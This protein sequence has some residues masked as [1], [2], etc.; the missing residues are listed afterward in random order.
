MHSIPDDVKMFM[1][2]FDGEIFKM[3]FTESSIPYEN[4]RFTGFVDPYIHARFVGFTLALKLRDKFDHVHQESLA[5]V[6]TD[7]QRLDRILNN[8]H[9]RIV[10]VENDPIGESM[11]NNI[12]DLISTGAS[13]RDAMDAAFVNYENYKCSS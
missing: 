9:I 13:N 5:K 4:P 12:V 3:E 7:T 2:C 6:V 10:P 1:E 8:P 11:L